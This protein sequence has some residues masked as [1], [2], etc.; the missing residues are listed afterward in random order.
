M[1]EIKSNALNRTNNRDC[2]PNYVLPSDKYKYHGLYEGVD[3]VGHVYLDV[4][5]VVAVRANVSTLKEPNWIYSISKKS[6]QLL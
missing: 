2:A 3:F 1:K 6:C 4:T 5:G